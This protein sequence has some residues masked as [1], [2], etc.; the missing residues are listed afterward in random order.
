MTLIERLLAADVFAAS[1]LGNMPCR[2]VD[3]P[4]GSATHDVKVI[5]VGLDTRDEIVS[6]LTAYAEQAGEKG[7]S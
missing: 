7:C 1:E 6:A 3:E 2:R 4:E 5:L